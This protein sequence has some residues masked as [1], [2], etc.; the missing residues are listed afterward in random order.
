MR[1]AG[2][3]LAV[4]IAVAA[5]TAL[6]QQ[7]R[8]TDQ[9]GQIHY[10]DTPPPPSAKDVRKKGSA[11][12][13]AGT[14]TVPYDLEKAQ[15]D[16]PVT[17][18]THPTCTDTC[19]FARNLLNRRGVPFNEVVVATN[20]ALEDL[21]KLSGN[22]HVPVLTVGTR[23]EKDVSEAAYN[24]LLD[25]GG[26]PKAGMLPPRK[27]AAPEA[28]PEDMETAGPVAK[29]AAEKPAAAA[30]PPAPLGPYAPGAPA[31]KPAAKPTAKSQ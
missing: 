23:I 27:Q 16:A 2:L 18:Y 26:Y 31:P 6:A 5:G 8:W 24:A 29:P 12:P 17:L 25:A 13:K 28:K 19:Q 7:Y 22:N 15:K 9:N 30:A 14:P 20:Q 1:K 4:G 21:K 10:T 11:A 3:A